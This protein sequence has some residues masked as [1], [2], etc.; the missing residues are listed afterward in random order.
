MIEG[1]K[2]ARLLWFYPYDLLKAIGRPT[3]GNS[4]EGIEKNLRRLKTTNID[5]TIRKEHIENSATFSW[6]DGYTMSKDRKGRRTARN[7]FYDH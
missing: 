7:V 3:G 1:R 5:T 4:Y 6:L 2:P